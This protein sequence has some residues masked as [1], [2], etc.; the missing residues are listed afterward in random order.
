MCQADY[1]T[2]PLSSR[3]AA[4]VLGSD[5]KKMGLTTEQVDHATYRACRVADPRRFHLV[6]PRHSPLRTRAACGAAV[7][8]SVLNFMRL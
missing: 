7:R 4:G 2:V 5:F 8:P 6:R 1:L 3:R